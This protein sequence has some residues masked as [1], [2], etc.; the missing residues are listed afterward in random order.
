MAYILRNSSTGT[1]PLVRTRSGRIA[2]RRP[3]PQL[4]RGLDSSV[5]DRRS[6]FVEKRSIL[7]GVPPK[8]KGRGTLTGGPIRDIKRP[9]PIGPGGKHR[10][11][12]KRVGQESFGV[13]GGFGCPCDGNG[14]D[15][16][17]PCLSRAYD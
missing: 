6:R 2:P 11:A 5:S 7:I 12:P 3:L 8:E 13:A 10:S 15:G 9:P 1:D 17:G 16:V 14:G 4:E